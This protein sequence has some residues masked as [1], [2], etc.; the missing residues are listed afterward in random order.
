MY[1]WAALPLRNGKLRGGPGCGQK[2]SQNSESFNILAKRSDRPDFFTGANLISMPFTSQKNF[3]DIGFHG[4]V[5]GGLLR[6]HG[7]SWDHLAHRIWP[8][9]IRSGHNFS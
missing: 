8:E 5:L 1:A 9:N 4:K 6:D 7:Q 2:K 3:G